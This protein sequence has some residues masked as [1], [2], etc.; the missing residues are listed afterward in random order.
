M[1]KQYNQRSKE[2]AKAASELEG[3]NEQMQKITAKL[4][5]TSFSIILIRV[6]VL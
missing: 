5:V 4:E 1:K 3:T 6:T 2:K